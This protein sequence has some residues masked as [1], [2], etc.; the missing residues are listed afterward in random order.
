M[1][2]PTEEQVPVTPTEEKDPFAFNIQLNTEE[3]GRDFRRY[4]DG[5]EDQRP[6]VIDD[7][8]LDLLLQGRIDRILHGWET[9]GGAPATL[10]VFGFRFHGIN[11]QRRFKQATITVSFQDEEKR[12][13]SDPVVT[14]LWPNGDFTLGEPTQID[15]E[16]T[17]GGEAGADVTGGTVVQAGGHATLK[18]E[19]KQGY[20]KTDRSTL[21]GSI[22]LDTSI[23]EY[24]PN[25]AV[26]LTI[27]ENASVESGLVT[28]FRAAVLL[29][30]KNDKDRFRATVKIKAKG[31]FLYNAIR[32]LRD[33]S[34]L[35]PPNDPVKF[36]PRVQYLRPATLAGFLEE[37]LAEEIDENNLNAAKLDGLA[38]VLSTTVLTVSG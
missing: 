12:A 8:C 13:R 18:W 7:C 38:G 15:V 21:T 5:D 16:E 3:E 17:R 19:R 25:N 2:A 1:A 14:A 24:G 4:N 22:V 9:E 30:R 35:S 31:N 11:E 20:K 37:K 36:K 33:I 34:G 28:D 26:R 32:G 27:N 10:V 29:T 6:D 23:R